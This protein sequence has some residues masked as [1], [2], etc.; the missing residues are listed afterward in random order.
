[1]VNGENHFFLGRRYLLC[2]HEQT[3]P[4][5]VAVRGLDTLDLFVGF[6]T[7]TEQREAVLRR[8]QREQLKAMIPP[9]LEQWQPI[10]KVQ[11]AEWGIRQMKTRW[12]SCNITARRIWLNLELVTKPAQCLEYVV[13]HE[14]THLL[15]RHHNARFKALMDKHLASWHQSRALLNLA[16]PVAP[17]DQA[18]TV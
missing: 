4:A 16:C 15:E 7:T 10:L 6:G 5:R 1:M 14:L 8:W 11:L 9:L 18:R 3:G 2:V 17:S 12:G 13:V